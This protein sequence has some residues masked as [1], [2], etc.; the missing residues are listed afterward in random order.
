MKNGKSQIND[1][2]QYLIEHGSI[3]QMQAYRAF[4]AP[5]TRLAAVIHQLRKHYGLDIITL[6]IEGENCYGEY[7]CAKYI[8]KKGGER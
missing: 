1:V 4:D 6:P 5:I 8:L 7:R 3:T 2:L